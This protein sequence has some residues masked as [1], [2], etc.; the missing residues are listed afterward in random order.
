MGQSVVMRHIARLAVV[1]SLFLT[2]TQ[3]HA[4]DVVLDNTSSVTTA[5]AGDNVTVPDYAG[6]DGNSTNE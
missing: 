5:A 4:A 1:S 6:A 3:V 2:V